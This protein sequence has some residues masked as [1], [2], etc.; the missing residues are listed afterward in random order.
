M[1]D[2]WGNLTEKHQQSNGIITYSLSPFRQRAF[3]GFFKKG[4]FNTIRRVKSE[5]PYLV[6]PAIVLYM[7]ITW[8][9]EANALTHS[10]AGHQ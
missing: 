10:K 9:E 4:V 3:A 5:A 6:P 8:A 2:W 1:H 7:V